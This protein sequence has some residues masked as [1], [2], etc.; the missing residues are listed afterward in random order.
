MTPASKGEMRDAALKVRKGLSRE[1]LLEL[2]NAVMKNVISSPE[3]TNSK[4]VATYVA[5]RNE[6]KTEGI[7]RHS[8]SL[9][10]RVLVP[11]SHPES[12]SLVFSEIRDYEREL[13]PGHF[14]VPEP[15]SRYLRP[16]PLD[17]ADLILIP[18]IAWDDRGYRLG[19]GKGYFDSA[20]AGARVSAITMGLGLE[21]QRVRKI[22]EEKHD[23]PLKALATERRIVRIGREGKV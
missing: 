1:E 14:G 9:G 15:I 23:V 4:V 6:V 21:S 2:S 3:Y 20:L 7:I 12:T 22:P 18:L 13:A 5:K 16:V 10:K 17:D 19:Y 11:V 8:L